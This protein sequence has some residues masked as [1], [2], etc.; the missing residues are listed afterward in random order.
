MNRRNF[1]GVV[2]AGLSEANPLSAAPHN[3]GTRCG[4][5]DSHRKEHGSKTD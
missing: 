1:M 5:T 4:G 3:S 2:A